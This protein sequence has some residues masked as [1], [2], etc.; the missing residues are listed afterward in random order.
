M[1]AKPKQVSRSN[2]SAVP[3]QIESQWLHGIGKKHLI[4]AFGPRGGGGLDHAK[5]AGLESCKEKKHAV[6][7]GQETSGYHWLISC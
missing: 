7:M 2:Y 4:R 3:N 5:G 1:I 6:S